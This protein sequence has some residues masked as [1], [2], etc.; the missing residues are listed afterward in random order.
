M[1]PFIGIITNLYTT[2]QQNLPNLD[3]LKDFITRSDSFDLDLIKT[4]QVLVGQTQLDQSQL[5]V[6]QL[7]EQMVNEM[8]QLILT[9][10]T[11]EIREEDLCPIC[12][13]RAN[14]VEIQPCEHA[15]CR[16]CIQTHL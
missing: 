5:E 9:A 8:E 13:T 4:M 2:M 6:M 10:T 1:A 15:C 16:T 3:T 7:L 14:N 11:Q 12:V